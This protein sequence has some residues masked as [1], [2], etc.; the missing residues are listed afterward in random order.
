MVYAWI[1]KGINTNSIVLITTDMDTSMCSIIDNF[2]DNVFYDS[3]LLILFF[4]AGNT[5]SQRCITY[6][7][8]EVSM[9][10]DT[11]GI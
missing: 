4:M 3:S 2:L 9:L 11:C 1:S 7:G 8:H 5:R 10:Y 6:N